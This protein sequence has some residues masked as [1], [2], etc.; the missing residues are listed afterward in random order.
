[1]ANTDIIPPRVDFID[2]RTNKISREW[3]LFLLEVFRRVGGTSS[4]ESIP[5]IVVDGY[6]DAIQPTHGLTPSPFIDVDPSRFQIQQ[7]EASLSQLR[8]ELTDFRSLVETAPTAMDSVSSGS[9]VTLD[10][11][12]IS[13]IGYWTPVT[14]GAGNI[15]LNGD[16]EVVNTFV[17]IS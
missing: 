7:I 14:D 2:Q 1:M 16:G 5:D 3:F 17:C 12:T 6:L 10:C 11:E 13:A 8:Q 15:I 9:E 4:S